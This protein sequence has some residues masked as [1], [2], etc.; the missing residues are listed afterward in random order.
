MEEKSKAFLKG[1]EEKSRPTER[2]EI[3]GRTSRRAIR[4]AI[5]RIGPM[6]P[7]RTIC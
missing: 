4:R 2:M 5:T 3:K 6:T 7:I 1:A